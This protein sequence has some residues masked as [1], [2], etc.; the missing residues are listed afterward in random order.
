M[1][2]ERFQDGLYEYVE[3]SLSTNERAAIE[4]HL[5]QCGAC[6]EIVRQERQVEQT[7][8]QEF[9]KTTESLALDAAVR[10]H[11]RAA[12]AAETQER[13]R[14]PKKIRVLITWPMALAASLLIAGILGGVFFFPPTGSNPG[15]DPA[16]G[17][18]RPSMSVQ[19]S[20]VLPAYTFRKEGD[21]VI[22][23][24]IYATNVVTQTLWV[25][26]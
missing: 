6:R 19:I 5:E 18:A 17:E 2:C 12:F 14:P 26:N 3:G 8:S 21:L 1:N 22:D 24:L 20:C 13:D 7:L 9:E 11:L 15:A 16:R 23:S 10:R 4:K 25:G